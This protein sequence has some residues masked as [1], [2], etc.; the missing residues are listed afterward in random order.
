L[1][2][3]LGCGGG[4]HPCVCII[5]GD[6]GNSLDR[7]AALRA[8]LDGRGGRRHMGSSSAGYRLMVTVNPEGLW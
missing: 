8:G 5:G 7:G 6:A 1:A 2:L 4:F 3:G